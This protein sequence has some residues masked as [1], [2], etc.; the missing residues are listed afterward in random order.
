LKEVLRRTPVVDRAK[1]REPVRCAEE[2][3]E[4]PRPLSR[5]KP[6]VRPQ[7]EPPAVQPIRAT[8]PAPSVPPQSFKA[9]ITLTGTR[10][11][12]TIPF[13]PNKVWGNR[14]RH[15]ASGTI[16]GHRYRGMLEPAG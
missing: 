8:A 11:I 5:K 10:A 9:V 14:A 13:D 16:D 1:P 15:H 6:P 12:I 2:L 4:A 7:K 3:Q